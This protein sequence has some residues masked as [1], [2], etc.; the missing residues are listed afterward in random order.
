MARILAAM[1]IQIYGMRTRLNGLVHTGAHNKTAAAI[2]KRTYSY[3]NV[4]M[5][6]RHHY[7][8][9]YNTYTAFPT[10]NK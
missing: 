6:K 3:K 4:I 5:P 7:T 2:H 10:A 8:I 9:M 1:W